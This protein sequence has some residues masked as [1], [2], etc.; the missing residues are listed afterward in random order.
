[1]EFVTGT[2]ALSNGFCAMFQVFYGLFMAKIAPLAGGRPRGHKQVG[3][4]CVGVGGFGKQY[5]NCSTNHKIKI[6]NC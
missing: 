2:I 1:M 3:R 5:H 6:D 4:W